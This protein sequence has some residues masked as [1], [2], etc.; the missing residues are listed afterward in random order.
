MEVPQ[1]IKNRNI[2]W[3]SNPTAGCTSKEV[4]CRISKRYFHTHV[5]DTTV[6]NNQ[7]VEATQMFTPGWMA[8]RN[9]VYRNIIISP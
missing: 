7:E 3:S 5:P 1:N 6:H 8:K 4:E 2:T 9:L